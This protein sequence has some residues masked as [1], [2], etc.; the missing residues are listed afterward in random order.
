MPQSVDGIKSNFC[1]N[2]EVLLLNPCQLVVEDRTLAD[3]DQPL[4]PKIVDLLN[5]IKE[6][7]SIMAPDTL[8][9]P[10]EFDARSRI[11]SR[12]FRGDFRAAL[13][14]LNPPTFDVARAPR[15]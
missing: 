7:F 5:A 6:V 8:W 14:R 9:G 1:I 4:P 15:M 12:N 2:G 3:I 13:D 10:A 11:F